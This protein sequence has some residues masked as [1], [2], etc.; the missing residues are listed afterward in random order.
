LRVSGNGAADRDRSR[1]HLNLEMDRQPSI[2]S[3]PR[4][5]G[6]HPRVP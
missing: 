3:H 6:R 1:W 4:R 5:R 2:K